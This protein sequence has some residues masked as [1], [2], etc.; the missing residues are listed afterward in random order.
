MA[1]KFHRSEAKT[2]PGFRTGARDRNDGRREVPDTGTHRPGWENSSGDPAPALPAARP[3]QRP[4]SQPPPNSASTRRRPRPRPIAAFA[5]R[6]PLEGSFSGRGP[7][8]RFSSDAGGREEERTPAPRP[9]LREVLAPA[10][11]AGPAKQCQTLS[12]R[13]A[14]ATRARC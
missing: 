4:R 7:A 13:V 6:P 12:G 9:A 5:P 14:V 1:P 11:R 2:Q 8:T 10:A 3:T